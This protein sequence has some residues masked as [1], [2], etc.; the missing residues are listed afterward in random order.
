MVES[1]ALMARGIPKAV[2]TNTVMN[3]QAMS[4]N[5]VVTKLN[6]FAPSVKMLNRQLLQNESALDTAFDNYQEFNSRKYQQDGASSDS[7]HATCR[8][9]KLSFP[10]VP[11]VGSVVLCK[12][13]EYLVME[14]LYQHTYASLLRVR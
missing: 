4:Y 3:R 5:A 1:L 9:A 10:V 11:T 13:N 2:T 6:E 8:L 12:T 7:M 14:I